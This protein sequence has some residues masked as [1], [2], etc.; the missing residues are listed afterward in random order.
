MKKIK[1]LGLATLLAFISCNKSN[2]LVDI[3]SKIEKDTG[4]IDLVLSISEKKETDSTFVYSAIGLY[5]SV[6]VGI[7][8]SLKK[9]IKAGIVNGEMKNAFVNKGISIKSI[10]D[11]SNKFLNSISEL[12]GI[13]KQNLIMK[14]G[15]IILT[16]A[17][18]N[19]KDIDY[20]NGQYKFKIFMETENDAPELFVNFD[21]NEN[22]IQLN[23]KDTEYRNG[24]V[25]YL[26]KK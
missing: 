6:E 19:D 9:G 1:Y 10:G 12:Y 21:F 22:Q 23:E 25:D 17:N 4:F 7:E 20:E 13:P 11:K 24:I 8:I 2:E 16:C 3:T 15:E 5:N 18:L 14:S 26:T